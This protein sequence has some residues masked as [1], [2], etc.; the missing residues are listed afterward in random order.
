MGKRYWELGILIS[1]SVDQE[2]RWA[3]GRS[4]PAACTD[5]GASANRWEIT[6]AAE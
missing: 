3:D 1:D 6:S 5:E 4:Y 2:R